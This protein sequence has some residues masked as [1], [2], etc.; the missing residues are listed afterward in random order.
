M[1]TAVDQHLG[2]GDKAIRRN[3]F[4]LIFGVRGCLS[5]AAIDTAIALDENSSVLDEDDL[6]DDDEKDI[7]DVCHPFIEASDKSVCFISSSFKDFLAAHVQQS[8]N[9]EHNLRI[10]DQDSDEY[11]AR[12]CI[13]V[14]SLARYC[15]TRRI[16][17]LLSTNVCSPS[18]ASSDA[19]VEDDSDDEPNADAFYEYAAR[20]WFHHLTALPH[21]SRDL[22]KKANVFI[23]S[24]GFVYWA[25]YLRSRD[26]A[27]SIPF[28]VYGDLR[29]WASSLPDDLSAIV[30]L[31]RYFEGQYKDLSDQFRMEGHDRLLQWLCLWE[32]ADYYGLS[33]TL[34]VA[35]PLRKLIVKGLTKLL[36]DEHALTL[37]A[38]AKSALIDLKQGRMREARDAFLQIASV[39][40]D[41][42]S[43]DRPDLYSSLQFAGAAAFHMTDFLASQAMEEESFEGYTR[44][45]GAFESDTLTSMLYLGY[46]ASG[47]GRD[48]DAFDIFNRVF[49]QYSQKQGPESGLSLMALVARCQVDRVQN[50]LERARSGLETAWQA[51]LRLWG[52]NSG[53]PVIDTAVQLIIVHREQG[54]RAAA[55]ALIDVLETAGALKELFLQRC[56]VTHLQALMEYDEGDYASSVELLRALLD[57]TPRNL[58]NRWLLWV[59]LTLA[60]MLRELGDPDGTSM[61]LFSGLLRDASTAPEATLLLNE[62]DPPRL[63]KIAEEA[64]SLVR[65][66]KDAEANSLLRGEKCEWVRE[67]DFWIPLGGPAA[68]TGMMKGP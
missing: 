20:N 17:A 19:S 39:Q 56:Q 57:E 10:S 51:R 33:A 64:L 23:N 48:Q 43:R 24:P 50:R 11:F 4:L 14:L 45:T 47:L 30:H 63:L 12:K 32:L 13:A 15:S 65:R 5:P 52:I 44:T 42:V 22:L 36:G 18:A 34:E 54:D 29:R 66:R 21:P 8:P 49:E 61:M 53:R 59:R 68:D 16:G 31:E 35:D 28:M 1:L 67:E 38:S 6:F 25:E 37:R 41:A 9:P 40:R 62:P 7:R 60:A 55:R 2:P 3:I 46:S 26:H 27:F 58:N